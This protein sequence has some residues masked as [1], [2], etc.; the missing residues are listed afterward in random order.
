MISGGMRND[1]E[2]FSKMLSDAGQSDSVLSNKVS[3]LNMT[4][5]R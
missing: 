5:L 4:I 1:I 2:R 3:R